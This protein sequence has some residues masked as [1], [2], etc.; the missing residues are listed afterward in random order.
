MPRVDQGDETVSNGPADLT[1]LVV[2]SPKPYACFTRQYFRFTFGRLEDLDND[3]CALADV[4]DALDEGQPL[5][6]VLR[7]VALTEHFKDRSFV[8]PTTEGE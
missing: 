6:E 1:D 3:A 4:K 5:A 7:A 8:E 2:A